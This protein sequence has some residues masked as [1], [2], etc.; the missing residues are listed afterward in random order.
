M[1]C[2]LHLHGNG[3]GVGKSTR[4]NHSHCS[5]LVGAREDLTGK[6]AR[7]LHPASARL[8]GDRAVTRPRPTRH[9]TAGWDSKSGQNPTGS[10]QQSRSKGPLLLRCLSVECPVSRERQVV[11]PSESLGDVRRN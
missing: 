6:E 7:P 1:G 3:V 2:H 8:R 9:A 5:R 10:G 11:L 4:E